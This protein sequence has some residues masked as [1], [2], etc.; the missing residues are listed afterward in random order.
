MA[1]SYTAKDITVL[2]GLEPVRKRPGMYIGGVGAPGLHHLV[3]EIVDNAVDEAMNGHAA[4]IGL[5]LHA[6]GS[7]VTV[8][9]D[10]R[11]IPVD[12]HAKTKKS[13]LEVIFTTLHAGGKFEQQT[14]KTAGGLHGVGAS[15]VNAL[16]KELVA[17]SKRDGRHW[18]QKFKRGKP[19]G[20]VKKL[21][22]A[23]GTGTTVFFRPDPT[24]FP[25]VQFDGE[26]LADRMEIISYLHQGL[27][28][29]FE[30]ETRKT[31]VV[32]QHNDGLV[33]Y[34]A[35]L[36]S[37]RSAKTVHDAPF[38]MLKD[39]NGS[40]AR[41]GLVLQWTEST[42]ESLRSYVNGIPTG[43]GGTHE[44]GFRAGLGKAL[45][46]FIET[47]KLAPKG[48]T[49]ASE[50]LREGLVGVLSVFMGNP[51]F[52]GQTKDRLNN[53]E[54]TAVVDATVR[55]AVEHWL[56]H[57]RSLAEAIVARIILAA[58]AREASRAAQQ[59]VSRKSA[60]SNRLNLPGK[61]SDC[62]HPGASGSELF[63]VEGDS[64]GGSAKQGRDRTRQAILPLRG[65]VLNVESASLTKVLENKELSDLVTALGCGL[66]KNFDLSRL[67]Y[68]KVVL[69][70]DA[71]SDGNHIATLLLTFIYRH[72]P[73]LISNGK[74]FLAQPPLYRVDIGKETHW[75]LDDAHRDAIVKK[76]GK[77]GP[78]KATPEITRFKGLGE[79]MPKVLWE[80]T[81]NPKTRRLL[82]VDIADQ[83][84]TDRVINDLMGKDASARFRFIMERAEEAEQ[85]DV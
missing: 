75:A 61:L 50:D 77:P 36:V 82:R 8:V 1:R 17:T 23:R 14:Y 76:H 84:V 33:E 15:V 60:T 83:I 22:A 30:D 54:L 32:H 31:K 48:V 66:G 20:P 64:A 53:P 11:G 67:R 85:L 57:N 3:W 78:G 80:T 13:A 39:A 49:I 72:L 71:D 44:N 56:N 40:G 25:K 26:W 18:Q 37:E 10:G 29:A 81:L 51:Q 58:R 5:T 38:T 21:G 12:R 45:R 73:Q 79:M 43:S 69:L 74:V 34:L 2:E 19:G 62:T 4:S 6:D 46:N 35:R 59:Q 7:S 55:P 9:D 16:S 47:H 41:I 27:K 42:E 68:G 24:I 63:V 52:Q 28:V 70:A 65:K